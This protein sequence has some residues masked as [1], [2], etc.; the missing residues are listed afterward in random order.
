MH[1]QEDAPDPGRA[2]RAR[3][4]PG[5]R[6]A[7]RPG[8]RDAPGA[9]DLVAGTHAR[10]PG[11]REALGLV[12]DGTSSRAVT[13]QA[14]ELA[15]ALVEGMGTGRSWAADAAS[16]L[17]A[18]VLGSGRRG[19]RGAC[20]VLPPASL[21]RGSRPHAARWNAVRTACTLSTGGR[22]G[23]AQKSPERIA[24]ARADQ[25]PA[26]RPEFLRHRGSQGRALA[27][28]PA[29]TR[30]QQLME[31]LLARYREDTGQWPPTVRDL[32][33]WELAAMRTSG[34]DIAEVL[35][36]ARG[37][38]RC[39]MRPMHRRV[40]GLEGHRRRELGAAAD[41]RGRPDQRVLP[42]RVPACD[43]AARRCRPA[44]RIELDEDGAT[45]TS[46]RLAHALADLERHAEPAAGHHAA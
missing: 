43:G 11:L 24:A 45:P 14:E 41:R 26:D 20:C 39:G 6:A 38:G 46:S 16:P 40:T 22:D 7:R 19:C 36:P 37:A 23:K 13:D 17:P 30:N 2:A 32:S 9:P 31:S 3:G 25:H 15:R 27:G 12:E 28:W 21:S 10:M 18:E 5:G 29:G 34:D 8:T 4:G 35:G 42:G 33:V 1:R 44:G